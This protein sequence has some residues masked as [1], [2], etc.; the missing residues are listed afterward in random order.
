MIN[1][2]KN[3]KNNEC[4]RNDCDS[5][6]CCI[7]FVNY[8]DDYS[9]EVESIERYCVINKEYNHPENCKFSNK[10][11]EDYLVQL[12]DISYTGKSEEEIKECLVK[13]LNY[14]S[15]AMFGYTGQENVYN[16]DICKDTKDI[17]DDV[18]IRKEMDMFN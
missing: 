1:K 17:C 7:K 16:S 9:D 14:I 2:T 4:K 13:I 15:H 18:N 5:C 11:F 6:K 10:F 3:I 8:K 12:S